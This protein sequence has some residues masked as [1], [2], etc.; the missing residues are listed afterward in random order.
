MKNK[1]FIFILL[2]IGC[3][4]GLTGCFL[5]E[6]EPEDGES[7]AVVEAA[8]D[9]TEVTTPPTAT[10]EPEPTATPTVVTIEATTE[11]GTATPEPPTPTPTPTVNP[12]SSRG[13]QTTPGELDIIAAKAEAGT[14]PYASAVTHVL[15]EADKRWEYDLDEVESCKGSN[16]PKWLDDTNGTSRLYGR[17]LAYHLTD[18]PHYAE[19]V[20]TFLEQIMTEVRQI[21]IEERQCMLNF[22]WGTPE[23]VAAADL[24][25]DYWAD[26]SCE[27]PVSTLY[28]NTA[29]GRDNCKLLFQNWLVKNPYY[30]ISYAAEETHSNWGAAGTNAL[31]YIADYLWDRPNIQIVHRYPPQ[32][33]EGE[34]VTFSPAEAY[35]YVNQL[36]IDRMNGYKV[37]YLRTSCGLLEGDQQTDEFPP[38]KSQITENGIIP[39]DARREEFCN[40][41]AY[42]GE[43]QNYPE[44]HLG[45][46][47]QQC[48]LMLRRGDSSCFD[49]VD[50]TDIPNFAYIDRKGNKQVTHLYPG[51]GSIE[52]AIKAL[53]VDAQ[54]EISRTSAI[55]VAYRYY[56]HHHTLDGFDQ[57]FDVLDRPGSCRQDV[58]FGTLTHGFAEDEVPQPPPTVEPPQE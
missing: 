15:R 42:N 22:G 40:I 27:G 6:S 14:E 46:N 36:T 29:L 31:A 8:E 54:M 24:I 23:L 55:E 37:D 12:Y 21:D 39:E 19:E 9:E 53:I 26:R 56:Y 30:I 44:V 13:Y 51:R 57:W 38:V 18:E 33:N 5:L 32:I 47:I 43:Y 34:P 45:N 10:A 48:E 25:E 58:C 35:R 50:M 17:A 49:N 7:V 11:P 28:D 3:L 20:A 2:I 52:R 16:D 41:P 4:V 1:R